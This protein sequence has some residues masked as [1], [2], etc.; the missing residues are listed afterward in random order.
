MESPEQGPVRSVFPEDS[1]AFPLDMVDGWRQQQRQIS[2]IL[3]SIIYGCQP[4][5]LGSTLKI[6]IVLNVL[7]DLFLNT[8]KYKYVRVYIL[9][10]NNYCIFFHNCSLVPVVTFQLYI[11]IMPG[12]H[13]KLLS[14]YSCALFIRLMISPQILM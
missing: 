11:C 13:M 9:V 5:T 7:K 10:H 8:I 2:A 12:L 3:S 6:S 4:T 14:H 1:Q